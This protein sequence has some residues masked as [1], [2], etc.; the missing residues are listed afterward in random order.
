MCWNH[1]LDRPPC[2]LLQLARWMQKS[3]IGGFFSFRFVSVPHT[4]TDSQGCALSP[5]VVKIGEVAAGWRESLQY[6]Q[7]QD[8]QLASLPGDHHRRP[9]HEKILRVTNGSL[10]EVWIGMRRSSQSGQWYWLNGAPVND[11]NWG[12]GEPGTVEEGQ[13]AMMSLDINK[14]FGWSK[15]HCCEAARPFC[16]RESV[17]FPL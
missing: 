4:H 12:W 2:Q 8:L 6:C 9:I 15:R 3:D 10:A 7:D 11:T 16:Y 14:S 17:L 5:D 1:K 13:C